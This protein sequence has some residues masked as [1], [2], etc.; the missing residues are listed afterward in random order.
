MSGTTFVN[1]TGVAGGS[2]VNPASL[3]FGWIPAL[4]DSLFLVVTTLYTG[5]GV[6]TAVTDTYGNTYVKVADQVGVASIYSALW[7]CPSVTSTG[8]SNVVTATLSVLGLWQAEAF[9][10]SG[11]TGVIDQ[12][13]AQ[14]DVQTVT[15]T[16]T[17][18][19]ANTGTG[20]FVFSITNLGT[21][22]PP[23]GLSNPPAGFTTINFVDYA[24]LPGY[25]N[26]CHVTAYKI[27]VGTGTTDSCT[28]NFTLKGAFNTCSI[29]ASFKGTAA[30]G[31]GGPS[32]VWGG[33]EGLIGGAASQGLA[34]TASGKGLWDGVPGLR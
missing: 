30:S 13:K 19:G 22:T 9:D 1:T 29:I 11:L 17:N 21:G 5:S 23:S 18:P 32:G 15:E 12:F 34:G 27:D 4:G 3:P 6:V 26:Q 25:T 7:W 8:A 28:W 2:S 10:V 14:T 24:G 20:D 33:S 16:I 31:G